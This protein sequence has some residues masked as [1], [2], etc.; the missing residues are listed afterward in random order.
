MSSAKY[1][2]RNFIA[3]LFFDQSEDWS[4]LNFLKYLD[5]VKSLDDRSEAH[6]KYKILLNSIKDNKEMSEEK[7][8]KAEQAL[9]TYESTVEAEKPPSR[10]KATKSTERIIDQ[11]NIVQDEASDVLVLSK[12]D[13][14]RRLRSDFEIGDNT[15]GDGGLGKNKPERSCILKNKIRTVI[16]DEYVKTK[17]FNNSFNKF[18]DSGETSG[19]T[20]EIAVN[21]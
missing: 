18:V 7:R 2:K 16:F 8:K 6:H 12:R 1:S 15:E 17:T 10:Q 4:L 14:L 21:I 5:S 9:L 11:I 19:E 13:N 3:M 20:T